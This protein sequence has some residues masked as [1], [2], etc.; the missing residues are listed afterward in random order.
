MPPPLEYFDDAY[1]DGTWSKLYPRKTTLGAFIL[2]PVIMYN[3]DFKD[4]GT[5]MKYTRRHV[6]GIT[7]DKTCLVE[8]TVCDTI[9]FRGLAIH[10]CRKPYDT[11]MYTF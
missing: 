5:Y 2:G 11:G 10:F 8:I 3:V 7:I 6:D 1:H 4:A 9:C